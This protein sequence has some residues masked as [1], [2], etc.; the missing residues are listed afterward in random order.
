M[1]QGITSFISRTVL[2]LSLLFSF[3]TSWAD[4]NYTATLSSEYNSVPSIYAGC[5]NHFNLQIENTS[6]SDGSNISAYVYIGEELIW[7]KEIGG[8]SAGQTDSQD[9][10]DQTIRPITENTIYKNDN[11]TITYKVV[12]KEGDLVKKEQNFKFILLYNGFLGKEYAY[13]SYNQKL[14]KYSFTGDV[15]VLVGDEHLSSSDTSR[16]ETF[17]VNLNG[18][19]FNKVL[20]Y[21][22]YNWDKV[23]DGDFNNWVTTF[24]GKTITPLATYRDQGNLGNYGGYGYGLIV[25]DVTKCVA[26]GN[27]TFA[28]QKPKGN[29]AVYPSSLIAMVANPYAD[30]KT[31]YILE[32]ADLLSKNY[33]Q[34]IDA[35]Y[36]SSF[37]DATGTEA[38]LYVFAAGAQS[39]EGDLIING[40]LNSDVWTGTSNSLNV[41]ET[42]VDPGDITVQ[43][44]STGSTILAL[45]QMVVV[46]QQKKQ[47]KGLS[48]N[49]NKFLGNITTRY[50]VDA[51]SSDC[52][53]K[54]YELWNQITPENES[55]WGSVEGTRNSYNWGSDTPFNY[56]KQYGF[57][58]KFHAL[59]WGAQY[60]NWFTSSLSVQERYNAIVKWFDKV[61]EHYPDLPMID[62][63]N[64]AVG[65]HQQGN[66]LMK[67]SLGGG[68]KTGY[69][70]LIKAFELAHE[71]WPN[72]ILIYNDYNT[73]Q[74]DTDAYIE[75]VRTLRDA[76]APIDAY[77]CQSHDVDDISKSNLQTA[78]KKI[79]DAVKIP[80][81]I[82]ELDVN[83]QDDSQQKA[84]YQSIFPV[85]WEADYC[86]GVTIWGYVY[87]ATWVDHS[88]LYKNGK[89]RPAMEWLIDYMKTDAAKNA[90]SPF[91]G[92]KK[93]ISLYIKPAS[94][95]AS[96]GDTLPIRVRA[97]LL[98]TI[99]VHSPDEKDTIRIDSVKLFVKGVLDT[100]MTKAPYEAKY[101]P[102]VTGKHALKAIV[103][104]SNGKNY[105]REGSFMV[106]EPRSV[107]N[108]DT[109]RLPGT[110]QAENYD[111]GG[112]GLTYQDNDS[113]N[114]GDASFRTSEGVDIVNG[115]NGRA[116]GYTNTD[117]W[118]EY[119]VNVQ[120]DGF[121]SY[122]A[123]ASSGTTNSGFRLYVSD[124][125]GL[126]DLTDNISVPQTGNNVWSNYT[127][128]AGR[129][130][131]KLK[132][133]VNVI[134]LT[135]TGSNCDID[136]ITFKHVEVDPTLNVSIKA[137]PAPTT[138]STNTTLQFTPVNKE[139]ADAIASIRV[140]VNGT[141][142][143]TIK[144]KPF[145]CTYLPATKGTFTISAIAVDTLGHESEITSSSLQVNNKRTPYTSA[146]TIPGTLQVEN[147]DKG[148]EGISFHDSD[149]DDEGKANYRTDNEGVDI[150]ALSNGGY[151]IGYTSSAGEW[152]EYTVNVTTAGTYTI[153]ATVSSGSSNS[154]F[155]LG[156]M[157]NGSETVLADVSVPNT[158]NW[159]TYKTTSTIVLKKDLAQGQQV[160]RLTITGVYCNIDKIAFTCAVGVNYITQDDM[161]ANG[162]RYNLGGV[163]VNGQQNKGISI[164]NGKKVYIVE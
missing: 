149:S 94:T 25:Y 54:Y 92:G 1:K 134:R 32:E 139:R 162:T 30:P 57:T 8:I 59:V 96:Q 20:L 99:V 48:Q 163:R 87:G 68:G 123:Y 69:D 63:V 73:F 135:I 106:Y 5:A 116:I 102:N 111:K 46:G 62:V 155:R 27:N 35:I 52:P 128:I 109:V 21:V 33:N 90:K 122:Q 132:K 51:S 118:L 45:H 29:V 164:I 17:T 71:R 31:V 95:A 158:G 152:L 67:E 120:Q 77:G 47:A 61:K 107:F 65:M 147:F 26:N 157:K 18:G 89:A 39:G 124:E 56:A 127:T 84:Q 13:P 55:K 74:H 70:W 146:I 159:D 125:N 130:K 28:L 103:Y 145:Q 141:L 72:A 112:N 66:P 154:S 113:Q 53:K 144:S 114:Q 14:R 34:N 153:K 97:Q 91:P 115:N 108:N 140:Y 58:Y 137:N 50:Q 6:E 100:I 110:I 138:V 85:M 43:F 82:T 76:G 44:K 24:N 7:E 38:N 75:L 15:Q 2:I 126:T 60:P 101:I 86:A 129:T 78:M 16:V 148:G 119:T 105:E 150:V 143:N 161:N 19:S 131:I 98:D 10:V 12:V 83:V 40:N 49:P 133:G 136:K 64:E 156:L 3:S 23:P 11:D 22:S 4:T 36:S 41:F 81:Y 79:Q 160:F 104:A 151:A 37:E 142:N 80:M 88:G 9:F 121:Y 42:E 117:E 93:P